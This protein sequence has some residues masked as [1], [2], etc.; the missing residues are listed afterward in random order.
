MIYKPQN[1]DIVKIL[2]ILKKDNKFEIVKSVTSVFI[3]NRVIYDL[4]GKDYLRRMILSSKKSG[5]NIQWSLRHI[6]CVYINGEVKYLITGKSLLD[7]IYDATSRY[8]IRDNKHLHIKVRYIDVDGISQKLP[9]YDKSFITYH[10]W[11]KPIDDIDD[12]PKWIEWIKNNQ[13]GYL[14]DYL[15]KM[16]MTKNIDLLKREYGE[17]FLSEIISE[18]RNKKIEDILIS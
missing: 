6:F 14:D 9:S 2:P 4:S 11:E 18:D 1:N 8:D 5:N 7:L 17:H 10:D 3:D 13:P 15:D 16:C 12:Q